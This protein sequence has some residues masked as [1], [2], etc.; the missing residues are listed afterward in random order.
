MCK[1]TGR[2]IMK[3]PQRVSETESMYLY[4]KCNHDDFGNPEAMEQ[5]NEECRKSAEKIDAQPVYD[6]L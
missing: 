5:F 2:I 3:K 4:V 1:D 6:S